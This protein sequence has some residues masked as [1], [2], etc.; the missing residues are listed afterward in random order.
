[1]NEVLP[2][3]TPVSELVE[4]AFDYRGYVTVRRADGS[5]L[6]GYLCVGYVDHFA[7]AKDAAVR[8]NRAVTGPVAELKTRAFE[9][10]SV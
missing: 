8:A 6:V 10:L 1:M 7:P 9:L 3:A 5:E 4:R 2:S